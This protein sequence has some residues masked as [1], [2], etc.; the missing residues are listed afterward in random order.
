MDAY[1][2]Q[3]GLIKAMAHPVRL[4]ILEILSKSEAC[5]CHL[6]TI[7]KQRQPYVSQQLMPLREAGLVRDRRDG[8]MIYYRLADERIVQ[9]IELMREVLRSTGVEVDFP[10][11]PVA[12]VEGCP[13]PKCQRT[14]SFTKSS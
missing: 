12:P 13:C 5:V 2:H 3:V 10:P 7:L 9:V 1:K 11:V 8:V 6:T 4:H 14:G